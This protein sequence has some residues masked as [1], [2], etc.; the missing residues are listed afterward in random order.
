MT[1]SADYKVIIEGI[2]ANADNAELEARLNAAIR[3]TPARVQLLVANLRAGRS[4]EVKQPMTYPLA[5]QL[6][7]QLNDIGLI[8]RVTEELSLVPMREEWRCPAC[9][10]MQLRSGTGIDRCEQC[11]IILQGYKERTTS[12]ADPYTATRLE[13]ADSKAR[14]NEKA[15]DA[16]EEEK[17]QRNS[18]TLFKILADSPTKMA[19]GL[20][21]LN[22]VRSLTGFFA[23]A[24]AWLGHYLATAS[25]YHKIFIGASLIGIAFGCYALYR[26]MQN[27][28]LVNVIEPDR[29]TA[30]VEP[31]APDAGGVKLPSS[32][33]GS[34]P[35]GV[36]AESSDKSGASP[37]APADKGTPA[38]PA[39]RPLEQTWLGVVRTF[40]TAP[41]VGP[42]LT[43]ATPN[44]SPG[45]PPS[46]TVE[47]PPTVSL[48]TVMEAMLSIITDLAAVDRI[49]QAQ[50]E[51]ERILTR[52][53]DNR[54]GQSAREQDAV[55]FA[56][57][58]ILSGQG[59]RQF[60]RK[61]ADAAVRLL[62]DAD[63]ATRNIQ[64]PP[65]RARALGMLATDMASVGNAAQANKLFAEAME[66]AE[67]SGGIL[68]QVEV[69]VRV[70]QRRIEI[71]DLQGGQQ[72]FNQLRARIG[73][74]ADPVQR[75]GALG[76]LACSRA[77][78]GD[79]QLSGQLFEDAQME[80][81][82]LSRS[83]DRSHAQQRLQR[84]QAQTH[85]A[86]ARNRLRQGER[87]IGRELFVLAYQEAQ[88]LTDPLERAV[89]ASAIARQLAQAGEDNLSRQV[90]A[91]ALTDV[92]E[93]SSAVT[94]NGEAPGPPAR[95]P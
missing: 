78:I 6:C 49:E 94:E 16:P 42:E 17:T 47:P 79:A 70:A 68:E 81:T 20:A 89:A 8:C 65:L 53:G 86:L 62:A 28:A 92:R 77:E 72:L 22:F 74:L 66:T 59:Q 27:L 10:L 69:G 67:K 55:A 19:V 76:L 84:L 32:T 43:P 95:V 83:A 88:L 85:G 48:I 63:Q 60:R 52:L 80:M 87:E 44:A 90:F 3:T 4:A 1:H 58:R 37:P 40:R 39:D 51:L 61:E 45:P 71:A 93:A 26:H 75:L 50:L 2:R 56:R 38:A 54:G 7:R 64:S 82:A 29:Q 13:T 21:R 9:G 46:E 30:A 25:V 31:P 91:G 35:A 24:R 15:D 14:L 23:R 36:G 5:E 73:G 18:R 11:G 12:L 41:A 34:A 57:A 33:P